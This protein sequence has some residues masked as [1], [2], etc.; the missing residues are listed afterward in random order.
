MWSST[1][2]EMIV[3]WLPGATQAQLATVSRRFRA[4]MM[5]RAVPDQERRAFPLT[6][7]LIYAQADWRLPKLRLRSAGVFGSASVVSLIAYLTQCARRQHALMDLK[8]TLKRSEPDKVYKIPPGCTRLRRLSLQGMTNGSPLCL[9]DFLSDDQLAHLT[10][11]ELSNAACWW[12][13]AAALT[14]L[15]SLSLNLPLVDPWGRLTPLETLV[16]SPKLRELSICYLHSDESNAEPRVKLNDSPLLQHAPALRVLKLDASRVPAFKLRL[17]VRLSLTLTQLEVRGSSR[18][19][20]ADMSALQAF[21]SLTSVAIEHASSVSLTASAS[22]LQSLSLCHCEVREVAAW[23]PQATQLQEL[24]WHDVRNPWLGLSDLDRVVGALVLQ[25]H[26]RLRRLKLDARELRW[27]LPLCSTSL[28]ELTIFVSSRDTTNTTKGWYELCAAPFGACPGL[29]S[30][31]IEGKSYVT[32]IGPACPGQLS[33]HTEGKSH[34]TAIGPAT[35]CL[36]DHDDFVPLFPCV[37]HVHVVHL[38]W[39]VK[40]KSTTT[41]QP[42]PSVRSVEHYSYEDKFRFPVGVVFPNATHITYGPRLGTVY[43]QA[44]VTLPR[45]LRH[46]VLLSREVKGGRSR[47]EVSG[48]KKRSQAA[49]PKKSKQRKLQPPLSTWFADLRSIKTSMLPHYWRSWFLARCPETCEL[50]Y[51]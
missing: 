27:Q 8:L 7:K 22:S 49:H 40:K 47:R 10:S 31:H 24:C 14:G 42:W 6:W 19:P 41:P 16:A 35:F 13:G 15:V 43:A 9:A 3:E 11:L 25:P 51:V 20:N 1:N 18:R 5:D 50:E 48:S 12:P 2:L 28:E 29:L 36:N 32:A 33:L 30:L 23:L 17:P 45:T 34:V 38:P 21:T 46:L 4:F 39:I 44:L 37:R 26:A